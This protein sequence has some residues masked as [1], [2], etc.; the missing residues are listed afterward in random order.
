M[1]IITSPFDSF[2]STGVMSKSHL[3]ILALVFLQW[4]E[5]V[6]EN[7]E[8]DLLRFSLSAFIQFTLLILRDLLQSKFRLLKRETSLELWAIMVL[9]SLSLSQIVLPN[10]R[11]HNDGPTCSLGFIFT[12]PK[13]LSHF[14]GLNLGSFA[15]C[16]QGAGQTSLHCN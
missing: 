15:I 3:Q 12:R 9:Y 8:R 4:K 1:N 5:E 14:C 10:Y 16:T 7:G 11:C 2:L 13:S 6:R